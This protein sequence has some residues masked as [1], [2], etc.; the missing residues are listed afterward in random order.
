VAWR[1][2]ATAGQLLCGFLNNA[3]VRY[4]VHDSTP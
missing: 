2:H 1:L 3:L 4:L